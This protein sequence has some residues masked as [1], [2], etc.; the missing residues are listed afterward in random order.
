MAGA[1][2]PAIFFNIE[3][4][5]YACYSSAMIIEGA[6]APDGVELMDM[7]DFNKHR[8]LI[9]DDAKNTLVK[10]FPKEHNGVRMELKDV[11]YE[12]PESF[13]IKQQK[14][15]LLDDSFLGRRLRGTVILKDAKTNDVLDEKRITLMK[16][17]WLTNRGTFI[18]GGNE[19]GSISQQRLLPGAYS[20][21]QA[22]GDLETQFNVRTGTGGAFRVRFNP[23]KAEYRFNINGADLHLYSLLRDIGVSD[24]DLKKRWGEQVFDANAENYD[25]RTLEK[26]YNKIVPEW[27][28]KNN[29]DRTRE[30]KI[31]L[32]KD[33]LNRS[34]MSVVVAKKTLPSLFDR[35][36]TASWR[37]AGEMM[38]KCSSFSSD[39]LKQLAAYIEAYSG[40]NID[41]NA[42]KESILNAIKNIILTG[43]V[44]G[45]LA[46]GNIDKS[47]VGSSKARAI[48]QQ[49]LLAD[50]RKMLK[51]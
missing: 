13:S 41:T 25:A 38:Q 21:V 14:Q 18:K 15:A 4:F 43:L 42:N 26:A 48:R 22:N 36:K 24:D 28:K 7:E 10:A 44:D 17:P 35:T 33:A 5:L 50:L 27:D 39:E 29:P 12:D 19:W 2:S 9:F 31:Q 34:Q 16:V 6:E 30:Q 11:D 47:D 1:Y 46:D 49:L 3:F 8:Q 23:E 37:I 40:E 45:N 20:R 51:Q 32:I